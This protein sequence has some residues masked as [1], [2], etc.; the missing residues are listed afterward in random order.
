M[1]YSNINKV[2]YDISSSTNY[3]KIISFEYFLIFFYKL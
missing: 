3:N 1:C 2:F